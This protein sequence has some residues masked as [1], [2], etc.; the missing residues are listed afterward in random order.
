MNKNVMNRY[1]DL[2]TNEYPPT[3][4]EM[5]YIEKAI[6][7]YG[8]KGFSIISAVIQNRDA[9]YN[10]QQ[11]RNLINDIQCNHYKYF[12]L[13]GIYNNTSG[14]EDYHP[15]FLVFP[16][17][18]EENSSSKASETFTDIDVF[19]EFILNMLEKYNQ[20]SIMMMGSEKF[21]VN[22]APISLNEKITRAL[23]GEIIL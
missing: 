14:E 22:P 17:Y 15:F 20:D 7:L 5:P 13:Y 23:R 11:T 9:K 10:D 8:T 3:D 4:L 6:K 2:L 1:F 21:Y 18:N 12:T 16:F 19:K